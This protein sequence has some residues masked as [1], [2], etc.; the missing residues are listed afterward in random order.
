MARLEELEL[1][2]HFEFQEEAR[3]DEKGIA[4]PTPAM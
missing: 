4:L 3:G 2:I 1:P